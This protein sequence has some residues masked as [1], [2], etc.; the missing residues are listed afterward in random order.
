M[1]FVNIIINNLMNRSDLFKLA[2]KL[3]DLITF[4]NKYFYI[5]PILSLFS[6]LRNT[7]LFHIF[8]IIIRIVIYLTVILNVGAILYFTDFINPIYNTLSLYRDL[9]EPYIELI[10]H[11]YNLIKEYVNNILSS[12]NLSNKEDIKSIIKDSTNE[13]KSSLKSEIKEALNEIIDDY[14]KAENQVKSN[15]L[16]TIFIISTIAAVI[17]VIYLPGYD[18]SNHDY[19]QYNWLNQ[20]LIDMKIKIIDLFSKPSNPGTSPGNPPHSPIDPPIDYN[21]PTTSHTV[22]PKYFRSPINSPVSVDSHSPSPF[23]TPLPTPTDSPVAIG[24]TVEIVTNNNP[25]THTDTGVQTLANFVDNGVQTL[26]NFVDTLAAGISHNDVA[27]QTDVNNKL[28]VKRIISE[29]VQTNVSNI[30]PDKVLN[31]QIM[32]EK[33]TKAANKHPEIRTFLNRILGIED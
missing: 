29:A 23:P 27:V 32:V 33:L 16:T 28:I 22:T 21:S 31:D 30:N 13:V 1:N 19:A 2:H 24:N 15:M 4:L 6:T 8:S 17:Y 5:L 18:V 3:N 10:K 7:K 9:L 12:M 14:D 20:S 26:S 25:L 11:F